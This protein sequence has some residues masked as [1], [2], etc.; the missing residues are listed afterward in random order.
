MF[1]WKGYTLKDCTNNIYHIRKY[2]EKRL[3][4]GFYRTSSRTSL[5]EAYPN[6]RMPHTLPHALGSDILIFGKPNQ[7]QH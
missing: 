4:V 6:F 3:I 2:W 7:Q 1:A 5:G